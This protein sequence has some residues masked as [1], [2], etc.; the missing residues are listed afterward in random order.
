L[1]I[2]QAEEQDKKLEQSQL[3]LILLEIRD[4]EDT[5]EMNFDTATSEREIIKK[6]ALVQM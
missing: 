1:L 3:D 6:W 4:L 5:I 2:Q